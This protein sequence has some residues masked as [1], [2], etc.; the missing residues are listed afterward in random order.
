MHP[1]RWRTH[2]LYDTHLR[3][4]TDRGFRFGGQASCGKLN[5]CADF[6]EKDHV[7]GEPPMTTRAIFFPFDLFGSPGTRAGAE[8]LA[9]AFRDMLDDNKRERAATRARAYAR[10]VHLEEFYF[11]KLADYQNW[12]DQ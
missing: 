7:S 1:I 3:S 6:A 8:L 4:G 5:G 10:K 2:I 12:R 11:E 9:D